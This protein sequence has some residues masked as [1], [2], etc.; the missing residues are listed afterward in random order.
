MIAM[1]FIMLPLL[2]SLNKIT[3]EKQEEKTEHVLKLDDCFV[4]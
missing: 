4:W 3:W 1:I 2:W